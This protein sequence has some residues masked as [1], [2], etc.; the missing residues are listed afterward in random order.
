MFPTAKHRLC[1]PIQASKT[2]T[3]H[4][5]R[6]LLASFQSNPYLTTAEKHRLANFLNISEVTVRNW[7]VHERVKQKKSRKI[8]IKTKDQKQILMEKFQDNP[9]P[10]FVTRTQLAMSMNI[11]E[12]SINRWFDGAR[13]KIRAMSVL[14]TMT[15]GQQQILLN[16]YQT[17]RHLSNAE[18]CRLA[19]MLK[20]TQE[21]IQFWFI[22]TRKEE[23]ERLM[24][25]QRESK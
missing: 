7:F 11:S 13:R 21:A 9:F 1:S 25:I 24:R 23:K 8:T 2:K 6:V 22:K 4:Q 3:E 17:N 16:S 15:E 5:K 18:K 19:K 20:T 10:D 12:S 14:K